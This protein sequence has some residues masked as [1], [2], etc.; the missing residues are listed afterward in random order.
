MVVRGEGGGIISFTIFDSMFD[1]WTVSSTLE[2]E[3]KCWKGGGGISN[4]L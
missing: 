1:E 2:G 3:L 4:S